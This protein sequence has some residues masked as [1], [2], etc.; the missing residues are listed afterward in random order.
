MTAGDDRARVPATTRTFGQSRLELVQGDLTRELVDAIVNAANSGLMGGGGA[1]WI[2]AKQDAGT[3][4]LK[5]THPVLGTKQVQI[6]IGPAEPER[7]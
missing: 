1:I 3:A 7:V 4:V 2:R 5:V 6:Q